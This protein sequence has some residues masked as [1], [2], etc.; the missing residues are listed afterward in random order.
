MASDGQAQSGSAE[1]AATIEV[2]GASAP[3]PQAPPAD[4][5][6]DV[7][8]APTVDAIDLSDGDSGYNDSSLSSTASLRSSIFDFD[9][10]NG[11]T[12]QRGSEYVM[13]NDEDEQRRMDSELRG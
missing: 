1:V 4:S 11:R 10:E 12:Y 8:E 6:G 9:Q 2:S 7:A 5:V 3:A 13:P